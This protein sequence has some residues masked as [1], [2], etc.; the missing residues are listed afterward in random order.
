MQQTMYATLPLFIYQQLQRNEEENG[1]TSAWIE[2]VALA[3]SL[4]VTNET[5]NPSLCCMSFSS[6]WYSVYSMSDFDIKGKQKYQK[7]YVLWNY[8]IYS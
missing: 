8:G 6:A 5:F 7:S 1:L 4:N 3:G 2:G